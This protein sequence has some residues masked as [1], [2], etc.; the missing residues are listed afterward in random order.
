M[1]K[2][3]QDK[4]LEGLKGRKGSGG[5][6]VKMEGHEMIRVCMERKLKQVKGQWNKRGRKR[7]ER[8]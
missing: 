8:I 4:G 1:E 3:G 7:Q 6:G 2:K 5:K